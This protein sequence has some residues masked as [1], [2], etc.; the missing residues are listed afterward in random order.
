MSENA[1]KGL[2]CP[3]CGGVVAIPE[4]QALVI[5][6]FCEQRSVVSGERGVRRYQVPQRANREQA[7]EAY[8]RFLRSSVAIARDVSSKAELSETLLVH[9]PFWSAWGRGVAWAFGQERV[10]SGDNERYE[11]RE[12]RAV[13]ELSWNG[14]ACDVGEF[15]VRRISLEGRPLEP[16][17]SEQLHRSGMVFEPVG[18]EEEALET[19]RHAFEQEV[20]GK[21]KMDRTAQLFTRL[22]SPRLGV[23]YYP[24]WVMRYLYRGRSF[25]VV[26]DGFDGA[27]LYGK[28]P[29]N[30]LY[31]AAMLVGGMAV[32]AALA[33]DVP[34]LIFS[35][36]DNKDL[37]AAAFIAFA[38]GAGLMFAGWRK[39]RYGEH[40]EYHRFKDKAES[41]FSSGMNMLDVQDVIREVGRLAK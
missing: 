3:R 20:G 26:V 29:G 33:I 22:L 2:T 1:L 40:Y 31:R 35:A 25:Q 16:F 5:C 18:S 9:L 10:G 41:A 17:N 21:V 14:V 30:V 27:P 36:S 15:G 4:G 11:P 8:Q 37:V 39:Y 32:G 38:A 13:T 19:A 6:P 34:A 23:V 12:K 28:A 24:V 7:V